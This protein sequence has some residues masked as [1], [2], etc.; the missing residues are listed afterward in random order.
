MYYHSLTKY[1]VRRN[2]YACLLVLTIILAAFLGGGS[3][4][5]VAAENLTNSDLYTNGAAWPHIQILRNNL[6]NT[7]YLV[8]VSAVKGF[9]ER[10]E[11]R[12]SESGWEVSDYHMPVLSTS[13]SDLPD[14]AV[15]CVMPLTY[16][17][18]QPPAA[19]SRYYTA[20]DLISRVYDIDEGSLSD[21]VH[22]VRMGL[23]FGYGC[24]PPALRDYD[25]YMATQI[26]IWKQIGFQVADGMVYD[27]VGDLS[28]Y[29]EYE[30]K[31]NQRI[32][33]YFAQEPS[34][35]GQAYELEPGGELLLTDE[36]QVIESLMTAAGF[37]PDQAVRV[38]AERGYVDISWKYPNS[39]QLMASADFA[40]ALDITLE[41]E[42]GS[43]M[44]CLDNGVEQGVITPEFFLDPRTFS[45]RL[46]STQKW[47]DPTP[48]SQL[49]IQ[50]NALQVVDWE[51]EDLGNG[52]QL[53]HAVY[54][55]RG[56][57]GVKFRLTNREE[58]V[59]EE[60][61]L[62]A[63]EWQL[64]FQTDELGKAYLSDLPCVSYDLTEVEAPTGYAPLTEPLS[65]TVQEAVE[66]EESPKSLVVRNTRLPLT[67]KAI[68]ILQGVENIEAAD[69]EASI[70][71]MRFALELR[72][73][74]QNAYTSLPAGSIVATSG[75]TSMGDPWLELGE[76]PGPGERWTSLSLTPPFPGHFRLIELN[77]GRYH[78]AMDPLDLDLTSLAKASL[79]PEGFYELNLR[80]PLYNQR[81]PEP[82]RA[83]EPTEESRVTDPDPLPATPQPSETPQP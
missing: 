55:E 63:G 39:I 19:S 77:A 61:P 42:G 24:L 51:R 75:L 7:R 70:G 29:P 83:T 46:N 57:A 17:L 28:W 21:L 16:F 52:R 2:L 79:L 53:Y 36:N 66:G 76:G 6:H 26:Y 45:F 50:K 59:L 80:S 27:L 31:I 49:I 60:G 69:L 33:A 81:L 54:E 35:S 71:E 72:E 65:I 11:I 15:F 8:K 41:A 64:D 78:Q 4:T 47:F 30:Q 1:K 9:Q 82:N 56:L 62:A 14:S 10:S 38:E 18:H 67:L 22:K 23:Y 32:E 25:N 3:S 40:N 68:K 44:Y 37:T 12:D 73:D 48:T 74:F 43:T 20:R 5:R 13:V 58:I 34:L